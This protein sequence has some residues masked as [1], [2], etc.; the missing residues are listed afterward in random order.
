[1]IT[2]QKKSM[3]AFYTLSPTQ[4]SRNHFAGC[5]HPDGD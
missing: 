2:S 1:M 5:R 3:A 4:A